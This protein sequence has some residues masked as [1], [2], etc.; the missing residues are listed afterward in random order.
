MNAHT[1]AAEFTTESVDASNSHHVRSIFLSDIHLG[2]GGCKA[3]ALL[4]FLRDYDSDYLFLVGDI[5][6]G[7]QLKSR[8]YWPQA[9]NDV[10][11]KILRKVRKGTRV[12][13][14]AGNHDSFVRKF[15][16][17]TFGGIEVCEDYVH[18]TADGKR[19]W[20]TH[21]DYFD[22]VIQH[23]RWITHIGDV[24]YESVLVVNSHLNRLRARV[25]LPYWSL[26]SYLKYK[27]KTAVQFIAT[28]EEAV[29]KEAKKRGMDAVLCGHIHHAAMREIDGVLYL[30]D[31]DWVESLT[32]MV[33]HHDGRFELV[34]WQKVRGQVGE[35][36]RSQQV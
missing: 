3:E 36:V 34:E 5:I 22:G 17:L 26:S 29:A 13:Y 12:R 24:A 16:G 33:E 1:K 6:D 4:E 11:Q 8:W 2:S 30:N 31:G 19:L 28:F 20:L 14:I 21:G 15:I 10:I 23:S 27:V 25:G 9:H 32:A 7:W 35:L 18:V